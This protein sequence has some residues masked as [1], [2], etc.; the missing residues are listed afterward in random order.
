ML[1]IIATG[2]IG[3]AITEMGATTL[4]ATGDSRSQAILQSVRLVTFGVATA[5]GFAQGDLLS[6]LVAVTIAR[7]LDYIAAAVMLRRARLWNPGLD[8]PVLAGAAVVV[9][10]IF[11]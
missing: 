1:E 8:L 2:I 7:W 3:A 11:V 6:F 9:V 5:V 10:F 4:L